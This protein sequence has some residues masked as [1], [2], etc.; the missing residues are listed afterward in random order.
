M[1]D[2]IS[3]IVKVER[4]AK[5][6]GFYWPDFAS[7]LEQVRSECDEVEELLQ[8]KDSSQKHLKEEL[9]D[10]LH[11]VFSLCVYCNQDPQQTLSEALEKFEKRFALTKDFAKQDGHLNLHGKTSEEMMKYWHQAK[12]GAKLGE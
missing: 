8:D 7:V 4:E 9:G 12:L 1:D 3:R 10:L 6:Y 2:L 11:A 5:D